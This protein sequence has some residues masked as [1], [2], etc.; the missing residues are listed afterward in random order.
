MGLSSNIMVWIHIKQIRKLSHFLVLIILLLGVSTDPMYAQQQENMVNK[1]GRLE[2]FNS[3]GYGLFIH[4]SVDSQIGTVISHS[5]VGASDAYADKFFDQLPRTF[6]PTGFD[7]EAWARMAKVAGVKYVVF[8]TKHHSGFCMFDTETTDFN[9]MN[10]PYGEDITRQVVDA[11]RMQGIAIGF[12]FSP[13]DFHFLYQQS[14]LISRRRPEVL[15][16]NNPELMKHN[17]QQI[18]ELMT[19][20]G[21]IDILF[22]DGEPEGIRELAW[23]INPDL[24]ITRGAME[25]P[26]IAPSTSQGLP[27]SLLSDVW[28]ACYTMGTSWQYKPTNENYRSGTDLIENL[29][30]SRAKNG[31]MLLNIG[32]KPDGEIPDQQEQVLR[33]IGTWLF[34]NGEAIYDVKPWVIT[35]ED[36]IWYTQSENENAVYAIITDPNWKWGAQKRI[37]LESVRASETSEVSVLG[38]NDKVLEYN[39]DVIPK[40][41]WENTGS[42]LMVTAYRAQRI[43]NDRTWPNPVVIKVTDPE[44]VKLE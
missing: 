29:I 40:T 32:P 42:G 25:T 11:F 5:L 33:E 23:Q 10:T 3:L 19:N 41:S 15:P 39:T 44:A 28:E 7:A 1:P 9:I 24:V 17:K 16:S 36:H 35:N 12:Y 22:I 4:W 27:R 30:E 18:R 26:E 34:I 20:Y 2:W 13:D 31:N 37:V 38:Q 21:R 43:Y 6:D 8:T 14:I